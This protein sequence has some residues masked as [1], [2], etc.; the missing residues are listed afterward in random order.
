MVIITGLSGFAVVLLVVWWIF[1]MGYF[2]PM[3]RGNQNIVGECD[4]DKN[5]EKNKEKEKG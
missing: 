5:V 1:F 4:E 2:L 3:M